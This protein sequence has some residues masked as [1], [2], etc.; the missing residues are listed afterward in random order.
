[1]RP[2]FALAVLGFSAPALAQTTP[3]DFTPP[4]QVNLFESAAMFG[5]N[6]KVSGDDCAGAYKAAMEDA[7]ATATKKKVT[8]VAVY[9]DKKAPEWTS[10]TK[11]DC[12]NKGGKKS[13]VHLTLLGV[14]QGDGA[15]YPDISGE[16]A[17]QIVGGLIMGNSLLSMQ[18]GQMHIDAFQDHPYYSFNS[19]LREAAFGPGD[20]RN[21][22]AVAVFR[23]LLTPKIATLIDNVEPLS[24]IYGLHLYASDKHIDQ[25]KEVVET[26]HLYVPTPVARGFVNG[27]LSEQDLVDRSSVMYDTGSMPVKTDVDFVQ[28]KD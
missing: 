2:M 25:A 6:G 12:D 20:N 23:E 3:V 17:A 4:A 13:T 11:V 19:G 10:I 28:A 21:T 5:G 7:Q 8:L 26:F 24:E 15:A 14:R 22:R 1:M 9:D 27:E 16:R 18:V